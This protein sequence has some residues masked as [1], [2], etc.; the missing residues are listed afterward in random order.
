[1]PTETF[2]ANTDW[3]VPDN[4][5]GV[6]VTLEAGGGGAADATGGDG[7]RVVGS[8]SV[9]AGGTL[10]IRESSGGFGSSPGGRSVDIRIGGTTLSDRVVVAGGG[11]GGG[12]AED[13]SDAGDGG[14]GGPDTGATGGDGGLGI[15][16]GSGGTQTGGGSGGG[17]ANGDGEDGSFAVGGDG[18]SDQ[19]DGGGG[20][21]GWYGGGGGGGDTGSVPGGGGG[22]GGSNYV[23]GLDSVA[24]NE[25]GGSNRSYS[26]GGLVSVSYI[27]PPEGLTADTVRYRSVD[28]SW[29]PTS[30]ADEYTV[31]RDDTQVGTTTNTSFTDDGLNPR[32]EYTWE[33][34]VTADGTES[35]RSGSVTETTGG[36]KVDDLAVTA[37]ETSVGMSWT[38]TNDDEDGYEI[39]RD[40]SPGVDTSGT[41]I[42]TTAANV[43]SYMDTPPDGIEY[44]YRVVAT[45]NGE[46][47]VDSAE[48]AVVVPLPAPTGLEVVDVRDDEADIRF[49]DNSNNKQGY[50]VEVAEDEETLNWTQ[51][52]PD[53]TD[54]V[55]EGETVEYTL[56]DLRNGEAYVT[57]ASVFTEDTEAFDQ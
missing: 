51:N 15:D 40:T 55:A 31:Y 30:S 12:D 21:G 14:D 9:P 32:T 38:D 47:G 54:T 1:M 4:V 17:G 10:Y 18:G 33:V 19:Y 53:I 2:T 13:P 23:G 25:R 57:R 22:G 27:S 29:D 37:D 48:Q 11:G 24:A 16:G 6:T 8:L 56:T 45:R 34:T 35:G 20:G 41:P 39:H 28:L 3:T 43:E 26:Q 46:R 52:G 5:T 42:A 50:R 44:H 7:G 49:V 36:S